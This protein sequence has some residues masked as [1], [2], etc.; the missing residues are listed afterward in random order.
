[1]ARS[2]S[3]PAVA[4]AC[5]V[6]SL[7]TFAGCASEPPRRTLD[8]SWEHQMRAGAEAEGAGLHAEALTDYRRAME[9][10][11]QESHQ[12]IRL[13]HTAWY[14]GDLCFENQDLCEPGEAALRTRE[15]LAVFGAL[16]GPEHPVVIPILLRLSEISAREGNDEQAAALLARADRI[17]ARS[18]PDSHFMRSR[19]GSHRPASDLDPQE[20][21]R[22]LADVDIL[23]D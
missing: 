15:S 11:L 3:T 9:I 4:V 19:H 7:V 22:I 20:L 8:S 18:F 16:F 23:G 10:A 14:L 13:A 2:P 5:A 6:A 17:T 12:P 1:M 21:L